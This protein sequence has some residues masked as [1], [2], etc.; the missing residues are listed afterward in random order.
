MIANKQRNIKNPYKIAM[1]LVK[2][3][4][5]GNDSMEIPDYER[6]SFQIQVMKNIRAGDNPVL[7]REPVSR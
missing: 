3:L 1:N 5:S 2:F 6:I 4:I 7:L